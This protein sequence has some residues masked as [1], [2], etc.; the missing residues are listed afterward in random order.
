MNLDSPGRIRLDPRNPQRL[1]VI[2]GVNGSTNGFWRSLDGGET[3]EIPQGFKDAVG[4]PDI[5]IYDAY[6]VEPD[7]TD[8]NHLLV[9]FHNPWSGYDLASGVL[10]SHDGGDHWIAHPPTP[11]FKGGYG[12][13]VFFLFDPTTG[14]GNSQTWLFTA[15][16]GG[17]FRTT[18]S[19]L[20]WTKV[21][22][23]VMAHGGAQLIYTK[24]KLLYVTTVIGLMKSDDNGET[25]TDILPTGNTFNQFLA[26]A[27]DGTNL[28]TAPSTGGPLLTARLDND[29]QWTTYNGQTFPAAGPYELHYDAANRILYSANASGHLFA[30]KLK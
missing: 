19:G 30:L 5:G 12:Y 11:D 28:Y 20:N 2:D 17:Y 14:I 8:F 3:W 22:D 6:H 13:D 4:Q 24:S 16:G 1:Y 23:R 21:S 29:S 25:F 18:D 10:E 15:Q 9:T 27:S 7:P 26:L